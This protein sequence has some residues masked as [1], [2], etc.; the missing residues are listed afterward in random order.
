MLRDWLTVLI[1]GYTVRRQIDFGS[2]GQVA[3]GELA[4]AAAAVLACEGVADVHVP[5]AQYNGFQCRIE[6]AA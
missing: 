2:G 5:S 6:S 4:N 3:A 1:R